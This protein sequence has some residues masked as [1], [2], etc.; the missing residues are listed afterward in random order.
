[1]TAADAVEL[2]L[3]RR[4]VRDL[5]ARPPVT[6]PP[7][8]PAAEVAR[9]FS[10]ESVGSV[11]VVNAD[12]APVGIVTDQD[13]RARV[14]AEGRDAA[15][16][17][18]S[19]IMSAPLVTLAPAAFAFEAALE[20]T[21]HRIRHVV[22]AEAGRLLGVVSSRDLLGLQAA[23]PVT[24]ARDIDR[25]GSV[26]V[27]A[28]L[29]SRVTQL[30]RRL[31]DEGGTPYDVG[32]FVAQLNDRVV[33]RVLALTAAA[34]AAG[35]HAAPAA[36]FCW[37]GFGS[38]ARREQ[39]LRTDQDNGLVYADPEPAAAAATAAYYRRFAG[40]AVAGL[41]TAGFPPCPGNAMASN[42]K[43]CQPLSV[44]AGYFRRWMDH[45]APEEVLAACIY[46][47]L[48]PL[49][50]AADLAAPLEHIVRT[51]A[52]ASRAF[53]RLL[54]HDVVSHRVPRTLLG[55]VAVQRR[56]AGR[57]TVD[58]KSAG[59]MQLTGAARVAALELGLPHTNTVDRFRAAAERGLYTAP[60]AREITDAYQ[61]LARLR[62]VHQL[63]RLAAGAP[64]DNR[65]SL[66]RLSRADAVLFREALA[67]VARVQAGLRVRFAT[68]GLG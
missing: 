33:V 41:V 52:P 59:A 34:L 23:H 25:A 26:E 46:F 51:E 28:A 4:R 14:V 39:T 18:A 37:L 8:L 54:A 16:T 67:T 42:P 1:V 15:A 68:G 5:I 21:R 50:G 22:V 2:S 58:V 19:A 64:P 44:W 53:L 12:G 30:V 40:A 43:W 29:A 55:N 56:G 49:G 63:E 57:G 17:P 10:R 20:M 11:V 60:E 66:A 38:E 48:R 45:P 13:L 7:G 24:L 47:D 36:R 6:C 9:R 32:Q 27:L 3:F 61:H 62:L 35:G 31:V 65:V